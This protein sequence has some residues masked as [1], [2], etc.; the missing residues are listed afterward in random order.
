MLIVDST[1]A[2]SKT[3]NF[4]GYSKRLLRQAKRYC[5]NPDLFN[6]KKALKAEIKEIKNIDRGYPLWDYVCDFADSVRNA[7][8]TLFS[9]ATNGR[10]QW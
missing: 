8:S 1:Q 5:V 2:P 7:F 3:P 10:I 9:I 6:N 4:T